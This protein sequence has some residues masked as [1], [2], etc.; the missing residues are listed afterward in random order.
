[1]SSINLEKLDNFFAG[2]L[3]FWSQYSFKVKLY[4]IENILAKTPLVWNHL[5]FLIRNQTVLVLSW[6]NYSK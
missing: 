6:T 3:S 4:I 2:V 1:M 5:L